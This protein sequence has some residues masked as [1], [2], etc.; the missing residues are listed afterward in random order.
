MLTV[1]AAAPP[2]SNNVFP[3]P[4]SNCFK[5][6]EMRLGFQRGKVWLAK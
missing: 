6:L 5:I 1:D 2:A 3:D 4:V